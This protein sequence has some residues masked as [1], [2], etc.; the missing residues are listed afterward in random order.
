MGWYEV[1]TYAAATQAHCIYVV[2]TRSHYARHEAV[3]SGAA[4]EK[5]INACPFRWETQTRPSPLFG[6]QGRCVVGPT[7]PCLWR[8]GV[9]PYVVDMPLFLE[10]RGGAL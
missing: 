2:K 1:L 8:A 10:G 6:G 4:R 5:S 9:A 7:N 3:R